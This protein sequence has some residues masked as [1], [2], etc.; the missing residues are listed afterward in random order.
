M[1]HSKLRTV[2]SNRLVNTEQPIVLPNHTFSIREVLLD[3][4]NAGR[5]TTPEI[6][7]TSAGSGRNAMDRKQHHTPWEWESIAPVGGPPPAMTLR[8]G[9]CDEEPR[10]YAVRW[11]ST[12]LPPF[13]GL[14]AFGCGLRLSL[15]ARRNGGGDDPIPNS[16]RVAQQCGCGVAHVGSSAHEDLLDWDALPKAQQLLS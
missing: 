7:Q 10:A 2:Y 4:Q 5:Q 14:A 12:S 16:T 13:P 3:P 15:P 6:D 8:R 11:C 9:L 1:Q